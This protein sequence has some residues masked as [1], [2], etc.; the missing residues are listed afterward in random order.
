MEST[1]VL[2]VLQCF[3]KCPRTLDGWGGAYSVGAWEGE[4]LSVCSLKEG[5]F[6]KGHEEISFLKWG[7]KPKKSLETYRINLIFVISWCFFFFFY[8][9]I[10]VSCMVSSHMVNAIAK[11]DNKTNTF[12]SSN[13]LKCTRSKGH[14]SDSSV[15]I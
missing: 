11:E 2:Y 4:V 14:L 15:E 10:S 7:N 3:P 12:K 5:R 9:G 13:D 6:P 1:Y 8:V